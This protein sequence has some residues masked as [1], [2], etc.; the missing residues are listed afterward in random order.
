MIALLFKQRK[1]Q[2]VG[3]MIKKLWNK[4][5]AILKYKD[6]EKKRVDNAKNIDSTSRSDPGPVGNGLTPIRWRPR[7][8]S[9]TRG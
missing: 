4:R 6:E 2:E 9:A 8:T 7:H 5:K 1:Y 3:N